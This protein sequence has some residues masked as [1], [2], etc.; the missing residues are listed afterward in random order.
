MKPMAESVRF[1]FGESRVSI[2][3]DPV[4][5]TVSVGD[6]FTLTVKVE[7]GGQPIDGTEAHLDFDSTYLRVVNADGEEADQIAEINTGLDSVLQNTVDNDQGTLDY[8]AGILV[9]EPPTGT[10]DLAL[11]HLKAIAETSSTALTLVFTPS[12]KTDVVYAGSSVL[13]EHTG[14]NILIA[15]PLDAKPP[16]EEPPDEGPLYPN[17]LRLTLKSYSRTSSKSLVLKALGGLRNALSGLK[18]LLPGASRPKK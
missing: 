8:A 7:A 9:G 12:R 2:G 6:V 11:V 4:T 10:C 3:I 15:A 17:Y 16:D 18:A 13:E 1:G 14:A 5:K